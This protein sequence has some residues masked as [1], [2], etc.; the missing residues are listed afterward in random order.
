MQRKSSHLLNDQKDFN[1]IFRKHV[2]YDNIK[3]HKKQGF[4]LSLEDA[5]LGKPQWG[6]IDQP[7]FLGL[8]LVHTYIR[9][10]NLIE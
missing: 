1:E 10:I 5:F 9:K 2:T 7:A 3:S 4:T 6:Q 8:S